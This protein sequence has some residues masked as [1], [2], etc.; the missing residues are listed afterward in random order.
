[1]PTPLSPAKIGPLLGLYHSVSPEGTPEWLPAYSSD[2]FAQ[3]YAATGRNRSQR[4]GSKASL[5]PH[6]LM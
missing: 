5:G 4:Q 1:L 6:G 2:S 3:Q